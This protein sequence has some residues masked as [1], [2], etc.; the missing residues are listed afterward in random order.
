MS[1]PAANVLRLLLEAKAPRSGQEMGGLL[2]CSRA[3]VGKAVAALRDQGF[4]IEAR[5][6]A[7][8]SLVSEPHG[9]NAARVE[10]RL[11]LGCLGS[12]LVYLAETDS[13]NLEA[14][15]RAEAGAAHGVCITAEFQT[16][17]RGRLD[18]AWSAPKGSSLMFSLLLRPKLTLDRVFVLNNIISLAI[19]RAVEQHCGVRPHGQMAQ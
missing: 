1:N 6:R 13:T 18:R 3:A 5:S 16:A 14:R 2:G 4:V 8:Y 15:R 19:C 10:A 12:P 17:G 7:G 9:L 11:P